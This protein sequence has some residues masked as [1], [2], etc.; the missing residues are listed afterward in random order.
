[1]TL[2]MRTDLAIETAKVCDAFLPVTGLLWITVAEYAHGLMSDAKEPWGSK[3]QAFVIDDLAKKRTEFE[4]V[5]NKHRA[6]ETMRNPIALTFITGFNP[7]QELS[8][9]LGLVFTQCTVNALLGHLPDAQPVGQRMSKFFDN[10]KPQPT[11]LDNRD[12]TGVKF[13][14]APSIR[15]E[16]GLSM[17]P[18]C[19]AVK[20]GDTVMAPLCL[21]VKLGDNKDDDDVEDTPEPTRPPTPDVVYAYTPPSTP[22]TEREREL[23]A[24][25]DAYTRY[26][27]PNILQL[28]RTH[29]ERMRAIADYRG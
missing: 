4:Q 19:R 10:V 26:I 13:I 28:E 29:A 17:E 11:L 16:F 8:N 5:V 9:A 25:D 2:A 14:D 15:E 3:T 21:K 23:D 18:F 1:M 6:D 12:A 20:Y 7:V 24:Q 27:L 22:T